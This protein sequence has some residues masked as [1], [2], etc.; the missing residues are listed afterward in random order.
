M[1]FALPSG[2]YPT[3]W[4]RH[5]LVEG[6]MVR[7]RKEWALEVPVRFVVQEP[8]LAGLVALDHRMSLGSRVVRGML[9]RRRPRSSGLRRAG[10][11]RAIALPVV[12]ER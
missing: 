10:A 8:V 7:R 3:G 12:A 2:G 4:S 1:E 11:Q 9:R 6:V 5:G